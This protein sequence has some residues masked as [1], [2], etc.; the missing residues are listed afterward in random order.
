MPERD[1]DF[2]NWLRGTIAKMRHHEMSEQDE[3]LARPRFDDPGVQARI[4][5]LIGAI[6]EKPRPH[7][8]RP[9]RRA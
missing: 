3:T 5:H 4:A 7:R 9:P 8:N 1:Q 6:A 2:R